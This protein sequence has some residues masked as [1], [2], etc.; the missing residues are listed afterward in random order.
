MYIV[1]L[2]NIFGVNSVNKIEI[3]D[4]D[5]NKINVY[6]IYYIS[7]NNYY[8]IYSKGEHDSD[9]RVIFYVVKV[10]KEV[11]NTINNLAP[12]GYLIGIRINDEA[13]YNLV[14]NDITN[15]MKDKE[16][17]AYESVRYLELSMLTNLKI[18]DNRTFKLGIDTYNKIFSN[19][20]NSNDELIKENELLKQKIEE[21]NKKI[22][23]I[24]DIVNQN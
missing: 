16:S 9:N 12:T 5:G 7:N 4:I 15:I 19:N 20:I 2:E 23:F 22:E 13:E 3:I 11:T 8:F 17:N 21:L 14:K 10:L 6:G 1:K 24:K 18:K